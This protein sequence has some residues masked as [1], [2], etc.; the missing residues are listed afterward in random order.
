MQEIMKITCPEGVNSLTDAALAMEKGAIAHG[1]D[2][3]VGHDR[4]VEEFGLLWMLVRYQI[5]L[6]RPVVGPLEVQ[7]YLRTPAAA[8]SIRDFAFFDDL[9]PCGHGSQVWVVADEKERKIRP[10][11]AVPPL[12]EGP[13]HQ[14]ERKDRPL[15]FSLPDKLE[16]RAIWVV[17]PEEID[18]NGHLNNVAYVRHAEALV[19]ENCRALDVSFERECFLGERLSLRFGETEAAYF[20]LISKENGDESFRARFGKELQA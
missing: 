13:V 14:P 5:R 19:P 8:F 4:L 15:R 17:A 11:S 12:L 1:L 16:A 6:E 7:T 2:L 9:G 10:I 20:V 18:D 3:K